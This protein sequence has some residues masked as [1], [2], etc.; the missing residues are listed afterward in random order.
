MASRI[1]TLQNI[2]TDNV[3]H[4]AL[5]STPRESV[6]KL[7]RNAFSTCGFP[8]IGMLMYSSNLAGVWNGREAIM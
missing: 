6:K 1:F 2:Y 3:V 4:H 7:R 5:A 8:R